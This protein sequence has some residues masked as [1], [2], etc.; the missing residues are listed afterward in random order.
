[1]EPGQCSDLGNQ[2]TGDQQAGREER[3]E[4]FRTNLNQLARVGGIDPLIARE[5]ELEGAIEVLARR[6]KN[7]PLLVG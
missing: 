5:K 7:N 4:N 3:M 6:R 1:D 2:P